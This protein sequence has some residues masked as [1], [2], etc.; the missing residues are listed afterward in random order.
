[1]KALRACALAAAL[2]LFLVANVA[3]AADGDGAVS[4]RFDRAH[5]LFLR[6]GA[7]YVTGEHT[8]M[9][10]HRGSTFVGFGYD[11]SP[12]VTVHTDLHYGTTR[13]GYKASLDDSLAMESK[14]WSGLD[15]SASAGLT[16]HL[17]QS[18]PFWLDADGEFETSV[19]NSRPNIDT[20]DIVTPQGRFSVAPYAQKTAEL[21]A[22]WYRVQLATTFGARFGIFEP[23][24][25]LGFEYLHAS[26]DTKLNADSRETLTLLGHDA[27]L[28]EAPHNAGF[29]HVVLSPGMDLHLGK[30]DTI[31]VSGF[32][33]PAT[34]L[35][36]FGIMSM[37]SHRF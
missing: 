35:E 18:G 11:W 24:L 16:L 20:L 34:Q 7:E 3:R 15:I 9:D 31:G 1:M 22:S 14:F 6:S 21:D 2:P 23:R 33:A 25:M 12:R 36:S 26:L 17:M 28:F 10:F 4:A 37:F 5:P 29:F 30:R 19:V 8:G 13:F 27:S 32:M